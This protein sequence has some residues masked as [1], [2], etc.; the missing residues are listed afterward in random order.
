LSPILGIWASQ[1][2]PR[3]T[4]SYESIATATGTGSS[5]V[6]TFSSIPSTYKHLQLRITGRSS[7]G[8][9]EISFTCNGDTATNYS[10]HYIYGDGS[11]T[12][13]SG[14]SSQTSMQIAY[15]AGSTA[16]ASTNA[17][18]IV[19]ILDYGDANK[20]KTFRSLTGIDVN[21]A[22]GYVQLS[23]GSWRST[24]AISTLTLTSANNY[25]TATQFALYGIKGA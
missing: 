1:N 17:V 21:G 14:V 12:G 3:I 7:G 11:T 24:S 25:T 9:T 18:N 16:L 20:Y 22:G 4:S 6:I 2:Y 8:S 23:S 13:A 5:G 15:C 19:D 10:R